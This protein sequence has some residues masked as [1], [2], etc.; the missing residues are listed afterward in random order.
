MTLE[1]EVAVLRAENA[2]LREEV[3]A[4][5]AL[6][7]QLRG[8]LAPALA[9]LDELTAQAQRKR[10]AFVRANTPPS[11]AAKEPRKKRAAGHNKGRPREERP[12][13]IVQHGLERC[14]DCGYALRGQSIDWTRQ[15][16]ELP[17]P[18]PVEVVEHQYL[19][20]HC[21]VCDRWH[22]P[23]ADADGVVGQGRLGI[24]LLSLLAYLRT[25]ARLPLRAV[26]DQVETMHGLH[27]SVGG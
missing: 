21:P 2:R 20:R 24:R 26:Q 13:R 6:I 23:K 14:P 9:R 1:E 8:D 22:T 12:T 10:P 15:V 25:V 11:P 19:K 4:A 18:P 5:Q 3:A 17:L 16:V 27:L 7:E